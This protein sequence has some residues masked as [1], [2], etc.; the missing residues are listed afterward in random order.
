MP[1]KARLAWNP[2]E[3]S[4]PHCHLGEMAL[5][6]SNPQVIPM[7]PQGQPPWVT[8]KVATELFRVSTST[9]QRLRREGVLREGKEWTRLSPGKPKSSIIYNFQNSSSRLLE[10]NRR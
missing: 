9:L 2:Q 3:G 1:P 10:Q 5:P 6:S 8:T 4:S 7:D